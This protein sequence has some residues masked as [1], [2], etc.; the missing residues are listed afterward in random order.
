MSFSLSSLAMSAPKDKR[1]ATL[2]V[3]IG[4]VS[5]KGAT[6]NNVLG[7]EVFDNYGTSNVSS[8][9]TGKVPTGAQTLTV[10]GPTTGTTLTIPIKVLKAQP[11]LTA[12]VKP[13]KVVAGQ[14]K[15]RVKVGVTAPGLQHVKGKVKV[16]AGGKTYQ[17]KLSDGKLVVKLSAFT[18][19]GKKKIFVKYLGTKSTQAKKHV[20]RIKVRNG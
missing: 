10:T 15:A 13:G 17:A 3:K 1:D 7:I 16:K 20:V 9:L 4:T 12:K 14:T 5:L 11:T 6:V 8:R 18:R 19:A 2:D